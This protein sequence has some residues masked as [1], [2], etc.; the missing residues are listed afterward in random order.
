MAELKEGVVI[1][2]RKY[3]LD[4]LK[5]TNLANYKPI[6][7]LTDPNQKLMVDKGETFT[8]PKQ[9]RRLVENSFI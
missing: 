9:Y 3:T 2:Q 7:N 1:L 5:E 4:I 6:D 8:K